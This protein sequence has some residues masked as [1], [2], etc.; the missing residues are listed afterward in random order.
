[1]SAHISVFRKDMRL[2]ASVVV[3][4][5]GV[6]AVVLMFLLFGH[7]IPGIGRT[8][9]GTGGT[10][11]DMIE[12]FATFQPILVGGLYIAS[13]WTAVV[14]AQG[15]RVRRA[16]A[17]AVMLPLSD[18]DKIASKLACL[19]AIAA[20]FLA[21]V[22]LNAW[23]S[24]GLPQEWSSFLLLIGVAPFFG[25]LCGLAATSLVR[26]VTAAVLL[27]LGMP[28]LGVALGWLA[29][30][31]FARVGVN[32]PAIAAELPHG[33]IA[34]AWESAFVAASI[35]SASGGVLLAA[36]MGF[37]LLAG[38]APSPGVWV[39][40]GLP[41]LVA[42]LAAAATS[43]FVVERDGRIAMIHRSVADRRAA[44]VE[45]AQLDD[46]ALLRRCMGLPREK[47]IPSDAAIRQREDAIRYLWIPSGW[48]RFRVVAPDDLKE[49]WANEQRFVRAPY[50]TALRDRPRVEGVGILSRSPSHQAVRRFV[51]DRN[52]V[53]GGVKRRLALAVGSGFGD[54]ISDC[55]AALLSAQDDFERALVI[56]QIASFG[57]G[58]D[59]FPMVDG[60]ESQDWCVV[61]ECAQ[62]VLQS[63]LPSATTGP[64]SAV[65]AR[66][67]AFAED[68]PLIRQAIAVL[69]Q[70]LPAVA[71]ALEEI[72]RAAQANDGIETTIGS[73]TG[74]RFQIHPNTLDCLRKGL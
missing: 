2:A 43:A 17:L 9:W 23:S 24:G 10:P 59:R 26:N 70:P 19:A 52:A 11:P 39:R 30:T 47:S 50:R 6:L 14:V 31:A 36:A 8:L 53:P 12:R 67:T 21:I 42:V 41:A 34:A 56:F 55:A 37:R 27:G 32:D 69:S 65:S 60:R 51:L 66:W 33:L 15:D 40:A 45:A 28:L 46:D 72:E 22:V 57:V 16:A 35:A 64:D 38:R 63:R 68:V 13:V 20:A 5:L 74:G 62:F 7:F 18:A 29:A 44:E 58:G 4:A 61:L 54:P 3:P 73:D 71:D 1:M 49:Q 25:A 48:W